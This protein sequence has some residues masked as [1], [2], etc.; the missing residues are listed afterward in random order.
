MP[1]FLRDIQAFYGTGERNEQGQTLEEFLEEYD[2]GKYPAPSC[3]TDAVILEYSDGINKKLE[4]VRVLLIK[5]RNHPSIGFW[6]LPGGFIHLRED[7]DDT[8]RRE[9]E[10]ETGV[11]GIA[12]EQLATYGNCDR[13]PRNRVITTAYMALVPKGSVR[14]CAGDDAADAVWFD[15]RLTRSETG[16]CERKGRKFQREKCRLEL[17]NAER[18]L[19]IEVLVEHLWTQG[20]IREQY[21]RV[22]EPGQTSADHGAILAQA[23][24]TIQERT[25]GNIL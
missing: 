20:W 5:R 24:V 6:A 21:Y 1:S 2:P 7:L 11:T 8:A 9:L 4:G 25:G 14:V 17:Q 19:Q 15:V 23:M 13:D 16:I 22:M 12:M 3:T 10:E 18:N